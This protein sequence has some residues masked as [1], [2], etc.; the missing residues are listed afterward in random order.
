MNNKI[1]NGM[2][3]NIYISASLIQKLSN[4]PNLVQA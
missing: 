2:N 3:G 4:S 1:D